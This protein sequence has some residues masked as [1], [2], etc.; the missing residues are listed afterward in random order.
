M[1]LKRQELKI[2]HEHYQLN[3]FSNTNLLSY[4]RC[5]STFRATPE[6]SIRLRL[7][8]TSKRC[9][10]RLFIRSKVYS[11]LEN[12]LTHLTIRHGGD[13]PGPGL[14][15]DAVW[16]NVTASPAPLIP[17]NAGQG[18]CWSTKETA[19]KKRKRDGYSGRK[20]N[21]SRIRQKSTISLKRAH[22]RNS[23]TMSDPSQWSAV[24]SKNKSNFLP[25]TLLKR[26][27]RYKPGGLSYWK[28]WMLGFFYCSFCVFS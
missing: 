10:Q 9:Q 28:C 22:A 5:I 16:D 20:K 14:L 21:G 1:Y 3:L 7:P 11:C 24:P 12:C 26:S 2:S 8:Y 27:K 6:G 13:V 4:S 15:T 18:L 17:A 23:S 25:R 19:E